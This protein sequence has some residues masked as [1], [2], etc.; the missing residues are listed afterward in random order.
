MKKQILSF[1]FLTTVFLPI[2]SWAL[3]EA[4]ATYGLLASKQNISDICQGNCTAPGNAPGIVPTYGTGVDAIVKLP[5]IPF[6]FGLRYEKMGFST[7]SSTIEAKADYSRTALLINYRIIDTIIHFGPIASY[8]ISHTGGFTITEG[9]VPKVDITPSS[10][11]SYS[12]G[13]ELE[14]KPLI[15]IPIIVGAEA[16]IM[17]FNWKDAT[18]SVN[19][20]TKNIDMSGTYMKIFLGL[21]I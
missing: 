14:V 21:D 8:G 2:S 10:M 1:L 4:R 7:S 13:L 15:I 3:F 11:S 16:G 18:N 9:G 20:T 6:G 17:G 19:S 5:L 12:V